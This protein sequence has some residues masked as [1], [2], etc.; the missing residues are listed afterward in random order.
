MNRFLSAAIFIYISFSVFDFIF[1]KSMPNGA[2]AMFY[3]VIIP[4]QIM[5]YFCVGTLL[6]IA[7]IKTYRDKIFFIGAFFV[8]VFFAFFETIKYI[9]FEGWPIGLLILFQNN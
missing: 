4:F 7:T 9:A 5:A 2:E 3:M 1:F 8:L 6:I